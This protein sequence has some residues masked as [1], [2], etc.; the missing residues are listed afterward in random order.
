MAWPIVNSQAIT[1]NPFGS[2]GHSSGYNAQSIPM[3]SS[4]LSYGMPNFTSHFLNSIL[5]TSPN[6]RI[7]LGGSTPPSTPFSFGGSQIPQ[8]TPN[9]EGIVIFNPGSNPPTS[10]WSNQP[11]AQ[12]S[13][14]APS[15]NPTSLVQIPTNTFCMTNPPLSSGFQPRGVQFHTLG[16]PQPRSNLAGGNFYNPQQNIHVGMMPNQPYMN[17]SRGG[18]YISRQGHGVYQN[19]GWPTNPKA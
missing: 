9:M 12:A 7:G 6:T 8:I 1:S 15:Y 4:P 10:G 19:P 17:Q 3:A 18:P 11:G 16:N 2:L 5:A 14:Q 13:T